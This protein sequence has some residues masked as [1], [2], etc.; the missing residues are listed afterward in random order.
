MF[1]YGL[2]ITGGLLQIFG[3]GLLLH[4]FWQPLF[5]F[6][7]SASVSKIT[8]GL[9][10]LALGMFF[11]KSLM[12]LAACNPQWDAFVNHRY[13]A[14]AFM[15]AIFLGIVLPAVMAP[16]WQH[17]WFCNNLEIPARKG[18]SRFHLGLGLIIFAILF[19]EILLIYP[20]FAPLLNYPVLTQLPALLFIAAF[21]KA[22]GLLLFT[23][24]RVLQ[25]PSAVR[26]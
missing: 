2:S 17:G 1:V 23:P 21:L 8:R 18:L 25:I 5:H 9:I 3:A 11:I 13:T 22:S 16:A 24:E 19:S 6:A 26:R 20:V 15:H 10:I 4:A 12:Q 14:I 7:T